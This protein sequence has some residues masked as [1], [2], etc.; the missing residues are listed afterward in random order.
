MLIIEFILQRC[1]NNLINYYN[2]ISISYIIAISV[3][4][5]VDDGSLNDTDP[6]ITLE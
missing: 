6:S 1:N 4:N 3:K 5:S 2:I